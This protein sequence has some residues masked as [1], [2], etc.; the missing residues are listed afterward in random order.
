MVVYVHSS[1]RSTSARVEYM[2][3]NK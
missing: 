3:T 1:Q 2:Y